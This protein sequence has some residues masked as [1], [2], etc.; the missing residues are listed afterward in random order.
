MKNSTETV[1]TIVEL[2]VVELAVTCA[3]A[4]V[5][6]AALAILL[7]YFCTTP[8]QRERYRRRCMKSRQS[9]EQSQRTTTS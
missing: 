3:A 4:A 8:T 6:M 9:V 2:D 5:I 1:S 7:F